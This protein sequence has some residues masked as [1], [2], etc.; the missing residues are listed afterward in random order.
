MRGMAARLLV[1]MGSGETSPTMSRVHRELLDRVG[2]PP[3]KAVLIDTPYGFQENAD[4][5]SQ[6]A[7]EYFAIAVQRRMEVASLRAAAAPP[8]EREAALARLR[9]ARYVFSGPGSPSYALAQWH[10]SQ[11]PAI[12]AEKLASGGCVT[13]AS[14]AAVTLGPF[15]LPVYEIYK[16]GQ[17]P[18]WLEGLDLVS[19]AGL[20]GAVVIPHYN[21]AEGG[22]HDT[23]F[24]YMGE[25]RLSML[26][27]E[28]PEGTFILG[29]DEHTAC[30]VDVDSASL[31]VAGLGTVSVRRHGHTST[32]ATGTTVPLA[33]VVGGSGEGPDPER[34]SA[35]AVVPGAPTSLASSPLLD[36]VASCQRRFVEAVE[37]RDADGAVAAV[38]ELDELLLDWSRDTLQSDHLD[39]GRSVLRGMVLSLGEAARQGLQDPRQAVTPLVETLL[40]LRRSAREDR[41]WREADAIRDRL[42][43][44]GI[45]VRDSP[46]GTSW[47]L[48]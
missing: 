48:A 19:A 14:A 30:I 40:D 16:V 42:T 12:L 11:V 38:I 5:I 43:D 35:G 18:R 22:N 32:I 45:E 41:R 34:P 6:R 9:E 28:L 31:T 25:R 15:A 4:D 8:V 24:C 3:A 47:E 20:P 33:R 29:V 13:F 36:G 37:A 17:P 21:N 27:K 7:V 26:E 1:V 44:A 39:R 10:G 23:R 2:V 46:E